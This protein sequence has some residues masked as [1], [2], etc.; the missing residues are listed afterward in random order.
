[1]R[2]ES[3]G[4]FEA[5][6]VNLWDLSS[7]LLRSHRDGGRHGPPVPP[8]GGRPPQGPLL[9]LEEDPLLQTP[10]GLQDHVAR[11]QETLQ[12]QPDL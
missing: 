6:W 11:I 5:Q 10:G 8:A 2:Q 12:V 9:V 1:M 3:R 4:K 7:L